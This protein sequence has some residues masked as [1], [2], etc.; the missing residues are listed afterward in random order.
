MNHVD[1]LRRKSAIEDARDLGIEKP[2]APFP[3]GTVRYTSTD[4]LHRSDEEELVPVRIQPSDFLARRT[5]VLGMTRTGKSN[6][7]RQTVSGAGRK[8]GPVSA[9][10]RAS[11]VDCVLRG[12]SLP[13]LSSMSLCA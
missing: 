12:S 2:I 8:L 6:L 1:P 13:A 5:A 10:V 3:V 11:A 4:R 7:L 9:S